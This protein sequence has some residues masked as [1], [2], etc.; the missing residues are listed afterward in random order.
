M[1]R[2]KGKKQMGDSV[3]NSK[4]QLPLLSNSTRKLVNTNGGTH[5]NRKCTTIKIV[6]HRECSKVSNFH[7]ER[8]VT[9]V[10]SK[11]TLIQS[12]GGKRQRVK[13]ISY[14]FSNTQARTRM[15]IYQCCLLRAQPIHQPRLMQQYCFDS[16]ALRT[17][18][19]MVEYIGWTRLSPPTNCI[20]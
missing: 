6:I 10:G 2:L 18:P 19:T 17:R 1:V 15:K 13:R 7:G 5:I 8:E 4:S 11:D 20:K 14:G 12:N 16:Y 9:R 3:L